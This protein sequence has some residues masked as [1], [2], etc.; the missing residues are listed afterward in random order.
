MDFKTLCSKLPS[1]F[2]PSSMNVLE[3]P[4]TNAAEVPVPC[5]TNTATFDRNYYIE[6]SFNLRTLYTVRDSGL[7]HDRPLS[8]PVRPTNEEP[9]VEIRTRKKALT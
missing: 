3:F 2:N 8:I 6:N 9:K 7:F 4:H 1:G 5:A